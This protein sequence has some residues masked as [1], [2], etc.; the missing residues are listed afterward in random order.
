MTTPPEKPTLAQEG[1]GEF[2]KFFAFVKDALNDDTVRAQVFSDLGVDP[3]NIPSNAPRMDSAAQIDSIELY[4]KT[5]NPDKEAF[6]ERIADLKELYEAVRA[7]VEAAN[8]G[9][10]E[11]AEEL[12]HRTFRLMSLNYLRVR[13]PILF[14]LGQAAGF[15]EESFSTDRIPD[16]AGKGILRFL[17]SPRK[18]LKELYGP[19]WPIETE[20]QAKVLSDATLA[21]LGVVLGFWNNTLAKLL[22]MIKVNTRL[23]APRVLYGWEG[24]KN[25][26]LTP[27]GD[28]LAA[29]TLAFTLNGLPN[30][31][32]GTPTPPQ[33]DPC[34]GTSA[35]PAEPTGRLDMALAWVPREHGGPGLLV[36]A[37]GSNKIGLP[38]DDGWVFTV[39][40]TSAAAVDFLIRDWDDIDIHGPSDASLTLA[41]ERP[42]GPT[43]PYVMEFDE[44]FRLEFDAL[45]LSMGIGIDGPTF[46]FRARNS[47]LIIDADADPVLARVAGADKMRADFDLG[48]TFANGEFHLEGSSGLQATLPVNRTTGPLSVQSVTVG[49]APNSADNAPDLTVE[50]SA[51]LVLRLGAMTLIVD[52]V[53]FSGAMDFWD[54]PALGFKS[55]TGIGVE[56]DSDS[57]RGGG[58]L[59]FDHDK[60]Q[61]GGVL[62]LEFKGLG[63]VKAI[64]LLST[65]MPDATR[66]FS[67]LAIL[68]IQDLTGF[69]LPLHFR[70]TGI[71]GLFGYDRTV[72]MPALESGLKTRALDHIMFPPDPIANAPAIVS[73]AAAV[74]PPAR[75]KM[76]IGLMAQVAW[77][78]DLVTIELGLVY[79]LP[80][81]GR[82]VI[83]GKLR[84]LFPNKKL[85]VVRIQVDLIGEIDFKRKQAFVHA[86][87]I[88][89]KLAGFPLTGAAAML[90]R[91]G[92]DDP[93]F[94]LAF[95]G[96]HP[97]YEQRLPAGFPKL[98]RLSVAL[99]RGKNPRIRLETYVALTSNSFQIGGK[100]EVFAS[101]GKFSVDGMLAVDALFQEGEPSVIFD[102]AARLQIKVYGVNLFTAKFAGTFQGWNPSNIRGKA[103][104]EIWIFDYTIP[105][106]H[107]FGKAAPPPALPPIDVRTPL[108]AA[109]G[110]PRNWQATDPVAG[111]VALRSLPAQPN[112]VLMH[113]LGR[114][115]V[116]QRVVPL[117][118]TV[119][120]VGQARP[121]GGARFSIDPFAT[122]GG[123][124]MPTSGLNDKFAR[125]QYFDMTDDEKLAAPAFESMSAGVEIGSSAVI[126]GTGVA[127][128][129]D[130]ETLIYDPIEEAT[131]PGD[132]YALSADLLVPLSEIGK[133]SKARF[134]GPSRAASVSWSRYMVASTEDLSETAVPG[135]PAGG[136]RTY[137]QAAAAL[138]AHTAAHPEQRSKLQL[139]VTNA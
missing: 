78:D 101:I 25:G 24:S 83:L 104:F 124:Q 56:I 99:T 63:A 97:R 51:S 94:V 30:F 71:G 8:V 62:D 17:E 70:L 23:P 57:V 100:L 38:L 93:V 11:T 134:S 69:E 118:L 111:V 26:T 7:I 123:K 92:D 41:L 77:I 60:H 20:A 59:F 105:I 2:G 116:T 54:V 64:G 113:P 65:R 115:A 117:G 53:G 36:S 1:V 103:R 3:A 91:W 32:V 31:S 5:A 89:S 137:S 37:G 72:S 108:L 81:P 16:Q 136:A 4:R 33:G 50:I 133:E 42:A 95:G 15:I 80:Y 85:P 110:D 75:D 74:F 6:V 44:G 29:R 96:V 120:R 46:K 22:A 48:L 106:D 132:P 13:F 88:D 139:V 131:V 21:P 84:A 52:R 47:A 68:T 12:L 79:E 129:T 61:Y 67:F 18:T 128:T 19:L 28:Q 114:L 40:L 45:S 10:Q 73:T 98:E 86:V 119:D 109:L 87:L 58:Y 127:S 39:E 138:R 107:T 14:W 125:A 43:G 55:P 126:F 66:G 27:I 112:E 9:G 102:L 35:P 122:V 82:L 34:S 76:L 135:M 49:L 121:A 130:Y 90:L